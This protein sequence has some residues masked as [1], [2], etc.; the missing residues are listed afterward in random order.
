MGTY[1]AQLGPQLLARIYLQHNYAV[2]H[3][4]KVES[5]KE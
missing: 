4:Y 2:L 3:M 1:I 5:D